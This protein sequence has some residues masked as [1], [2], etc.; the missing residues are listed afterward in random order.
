MNSAPS[1][2][3]CA[4]D[5]QNTVVC[6]GSGQGATAPANV[7]ALSVAASADSTCAVLLSGQTQCWGPLNDIGNSTIAQN[8]NQGPKGNNYVAVNAS[9]YSIVFTRADGT[10]VRFRDYNIQAKLAQTPTTE[11]TDIPADI[12]VLMAQ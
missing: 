6:W 5:T 8:A 12:H 9:R 2:H 7:K 10:L 11:A 1:H 3:A 4:I